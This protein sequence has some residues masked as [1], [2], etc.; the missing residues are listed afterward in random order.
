[1]NTII[2]NK[3][4][5]QFPNKAREKIYEYLNPEIKISMWLDKYDMVNILRQLTH[6]YGALFIVDIFDKY[7]PEDSHVLYKYFTQVKEKV[8]NRSIYY[9]NDKNVTRK[10]IRELV[11]K[12]LYRMD[13]YISNNEYSLI[14]YKI[15]ASYIYAH[16]YLSP[17]KNLNV[18]TPYDTDDEDIK[19]LPTVTEGN[20]EECS[21][22]YSVMD[23]YVINNVSIICKKCLD[24]FYEELEKKKAKERENNVV[25]SDDENTKEEYEKESDSDKDSEV[26]EYLTEEEKIEHQKQIR[27][28]EKRIE[29]RIEQMK[30]LNF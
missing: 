22:L 15:A 6:T 27:E 18:P 3:N 19:E 7:F 8:N 13:H 21:M 1:M 11:S 14:N 24:K 12:L 25:T 30:H 10:D 23:L 28:T 9:W 2:N 4:I 17:D 20:C 26:K 5:S 16:S 29:E